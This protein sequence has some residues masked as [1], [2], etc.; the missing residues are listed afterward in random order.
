[1]NTPES[2]NQDALYKALNIYLKAMR[3]FI[4]RNL[5]TVH[6]LAPE[7]RFQNEADIDIGDF[8][9]IF[10][11]Y[12]RDAFEQC[13]DPDRDV[14]SAIG[15][16]TEA[17]NL[18]SHP[19]TEALDFSYALSRLHEIADILGQIN[20]PEQKREVEVIRDK[21]LTST[22]PTPEAK[23]K[24]PRRK[25]ADLTPWRDVIRPNTDVIEGSFRKSEFAADLQ[26]VF[27]G[28]AKT[29]EYGETEIFFNQT[30]ITP[31]LRELLV[32]TLKRLGS[33]G[34]DP[35]IQLKT[36][37]GGGK[38][39]SLI[40]LYHLVNNPDADP[41]G[42]FTSTGS[43]RTRV[44]WKGTAGLADDVRYYGRWMREEAYERI[45]H[46]YPKAEMP[47]GIS[48][49]VVAWLWVRTIPCINPVCGLQMPLMKTFQLSKKRGNEH[50]IKPVIDRESNTISWIVQNHSEGVPKSTVNRTGAYCCGCGT[51]VKLAY[52][53]E[54]AKAG[55]IEE[56]MTA[57]VAEGNRR[58][59]YLSPTERHLQTA[60]SAEPASWP[61]R[62][63]PARAL[64]FAVQNYGFMEWYQLFTKRQLTALNIFS[65]LLSEFK[66]SIHRSDKYADAICTY[67][68]LAIGRTA[69]SHCSFTW[70]ENLGEK[71]PPLFSRQAISMIWDFVEGNPF[72][73]STQNWNSQV[74]WVAKVIENLPT[75]AN[76]GEVYQANACT[77][78]HAQDMPV[79][80]TDP[81][82]Y[83]NIGYADLSEFF[84]VWLRP[85]LRDI[86]PE[87][88]A[89]MMSPEMRR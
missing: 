4:L 29:P 35:V 79:I 28:K 76:T 5:K 80:I 62:R 83:D 21:L 68:A 27:E 52:V 13:F 11:R 78:P 46:L 60:L 64:G 74:E 77:T 31:G 89:S 70:W 24:L 39:H 6:G 59:L 43:R 12:W 53:R 3:P 8:P 72:S 66:A 88:F 86:Y 50:W 1:M 14:R 25:A 2:P 87:L 57:M 40:A 44:P 58:K 36:G 42:M 26:E 49:T 20:A 23:P 33:K 63:L 22:T 32:N 38:T 47:D 81:P 45:G 48:A 30:Y 55:K 17:R 9:H 10:R 65:D 54:Q 75:S 71:I 56:I 34:G 73:H 7:D 85:L 61:R 18:V 19:G 16:I 82:Y 69:E 51:A 67:L 84:Y 15:I 41:L 37:F